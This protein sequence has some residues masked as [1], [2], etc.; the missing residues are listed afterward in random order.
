MDRRSFFRNA[1]KRTGKK[2]VEYAE[3]KVNQNALRWI[4]PPYAINE[5]DF[6]LTCT[7]CNDCIDACPHEV[8]FPLAARLGAKVVG[9]PAL[10][11]VNKGCH[12]CKDWP[13]VTA[14]EKKALAL[15]KIEGVAEDEKEGV[16]A[17]AKIEIKTKQIPLP[18]LAKASLNTKTCFPYSGP[19]CG[20]CNI[21]PV[22]NAL[23][24][25]QQR[26]YINQQECTGCGLCREACI[27][28]PS[29][30]TIST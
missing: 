17:S 21:C 14:C 9:T 25:D 12:L 4:R 6:L 8:I 29:A 18:K 19:E 15:P 20:A 11:L 3:K 23:L 7:R 16:D 22:P 2:A 1:F 5:L 28:N 24:W 27:V 26:P 30:I 13:C 10:D